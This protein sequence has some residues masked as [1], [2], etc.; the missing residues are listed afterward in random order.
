MLPELKSP[1][2]ETIRARNVS[3]THQIVDGRKFEFIFFSKA[4]TTST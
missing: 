3:F 4:Q 1:C 2:E